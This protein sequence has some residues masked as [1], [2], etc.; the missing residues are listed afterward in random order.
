MLVLEPTSE[1]TK[2]ASIRI[3]IFGQKQ[4]FKL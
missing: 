3:G 4:L 1:P 2:L